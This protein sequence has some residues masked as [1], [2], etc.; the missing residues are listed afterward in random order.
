VE[1]SAF[2]ILLSCNPAILASHHTREFVILHMCQSLYGV[3]GVS[4]Q[5]TAQRNATCNGLL[6]V[7]LPKVFDYAP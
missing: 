5:S 3:R 7:V 6:V 2:A 1:G 4:T